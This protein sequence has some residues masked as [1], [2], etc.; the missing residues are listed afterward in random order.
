MQSIFRD[1][2]A[3]GARAIFRN[4]FKQRS[5]LFGFQVDLART[6]LLYALFWL[7]GWLVGRL[8]DWLVSVVCL[9]C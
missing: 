2:P 1:G 8:V 9:V 3:G 5:I 4:R 6:E 7:V